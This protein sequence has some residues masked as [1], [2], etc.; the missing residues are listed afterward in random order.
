MNKKII[1]GV[2]NESQM[3]FVEDIAKKAGCQVKW[4]NFHEAATITGNIAEF[5]RLWELELT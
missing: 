4:D 3:E 2:W 5:D 1:G